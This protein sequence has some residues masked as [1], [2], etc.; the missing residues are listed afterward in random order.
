MKV[1]ALAT[2]IMV[3]Y[4]KIGKGQVIDLPKETA[5]RFIQAELVEFVAE[6][7]TE[8]GNPLIVIVDG[9]EFNLANKSGK[10]LAE[11]A[12]QHKLEGQRSGEKVGEFAERLKTKYE[13]MQT[14]E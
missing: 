13:A 3:G 8:E 5:E 7:A 6:S 11:F 12:T 1:K 14:K 4:K 9:K 10:D 2:N